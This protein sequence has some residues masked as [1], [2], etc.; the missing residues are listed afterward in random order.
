MRFQSQIAGFT[1]D[2]LV[3]PMILGRLFLFSPHGAQN[4]NIFDE[5]RERNG[6]FIY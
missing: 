3:R 4:E 5:N 6:P 1:F 2:C